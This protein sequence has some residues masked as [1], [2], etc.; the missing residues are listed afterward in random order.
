MIAQARAAAR[1]GGAG[2]AAARRA[3]AT[4]RARRA[5]PCRP[6]PPCRPCRRCRPCRPVPRRAARA[7]R[8]ARRRRAAG[9]ASGVVQAAVRAGLAAGVE[10]CRCTA[11]GRRPGRCSC[12]SCRSSRPSR[13]CRRCRSWPSRWHGSAHA[14]PEHCVSP[15]R[16]AVLE[17]A[18][19]LHTCVPEQVVPQLPQL[20]LSMATQ[21]PLQSRSPVPHLTRAGLTGLALPANLAAGA[22]VLRRSSRRADAAA[23]RCR[24]S[25]P[26][27]AGGSSR[28]RRRAARHEERQA[29]TG[30][31]RRQESLAYVHGQT[32]STRGRLKLDGHESISGRILQQ[33]R[34]DN[35]A[36][37]W[38]AKFPEVPPGFEPGNEGFAD[39]CLT[40]WPRHRMLL[41][42]G[43][44]TSRRR[45]VSQLGSA[46]N[47]RSCPAL[48]SVYQMLPSGPAAIPSPSGRNRKERNHRRQA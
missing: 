1:A 2:R 15:A 45:I 23:R 36:N 44:T 9:A 24:P 13:C 43:D 37:Y 26:R 28:R 10:Q 41:G 7:R 6:C 46:R 48:L 12:C 29:E 21:A 22:A 33:R 8:A 35:P 27:G 5:A 38:S 4:A 20:L 3:A 19:L 16:A 42:A 47:R 34:R 30:H 25:G 40:T 32:P 14:P 31:E 11:S 17:Q 39:L 18:L